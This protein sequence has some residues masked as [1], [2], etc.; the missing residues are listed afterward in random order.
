MFPKEIILE[1]A[2]RYP[3]KYF[4]V[5]EAFIQFA[6]NWKEES[7]ISS[8]WFPNIIIIHSFTKFYSIAGL[9]MGGVI[10]HHSTI[11]ILKENKEPWSVNG[12]AEKVAGL[13]I[14]CNEYEKDTIDYLDNERE[15][16][17]NALKEIEGINPYPSHTNFFLCKWNKTEY[18]DDLIEYLL[19]NGIY[20]R[21]CRNFSGLEDNYF[22]IGIRSVEENDL[23]LSLLSS[24]EKN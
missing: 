9:R 23:L 14:D 4:I 3:E 7:L 19:K 5:D 21:D 13:L 8:N 15:R 18:L 16:A 20:I 2:E 10:G 17:F 11:N 1:L 12:I 24:F 22:R 6:D